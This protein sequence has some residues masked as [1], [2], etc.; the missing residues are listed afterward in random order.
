MSSLFIHP[1]TSTH[2]LRVSAQGVSSTG[3]WP[4]THPTRRSMVEELRR[5]LVFKA[6][7]EGSADVLHAA[8][9]YGICRYDVL[10]RDATGRTAL[11]FA[12][13]HGRSLCMELLLAYERPEAQVAAC[14]AEGW[15]ALMAACQKGHARCVQ[16]LLAPHLMPQ[17][18]CSRV[19][20]HGLTALMIASFNG[21][22]ECVEMLL[23]HSHVLAADA[24]GMTALMFAAKM[25]HADCVG[26]LLRRA[27]GAQ[28]R[29]VNRI[30]CTN[31][32]MIALHYGNSRCLQLLLAHDAATQLAQ[33]SSW[34]E[35]AA[36][37][38]SRFIGKAMAEGGAP[39]EVQDADDL[40][41]W[42]C[43]THAA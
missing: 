9:T 26:L 19:T 6:V 33:V 27:P 25:D 39:V 43:L 24:G 16:S 17:E 8:L 28:V 12:A 18:Q 38:L 7:T 13:A 32:L 34:G 36:S 11:M 42:L 31:A 37:M 10:H 2:T 14:E 1:H 20:V 23:P 22:A 29:A 4:P 3:V 35:S 30:S 41:Q 5:D 15:N 40:A 21:H